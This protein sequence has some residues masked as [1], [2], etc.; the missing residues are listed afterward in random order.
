MKYLIFNES[1]SFIHQQKLLFHFDIVLHSYEHIWEYSRTFSN[2]LLQFLSIDMYLRILSKKIDFFF[3]MA[4]KKKDYSSDLQT[5]VIKHYSNGDSQREI[6]KKVLLSRSTVQSIIKKHKNS[7]CIGNLFGRCR[8]RKTIAMT[9]RLLKRKLKLDQWKS[10]RTVTFEFGKD[11][12]ILVSKSTVKR[13]AHE[14]ALFGRVVRKKPY[15]N[16]TNRLKRLKYAKERLRKPLR[17]LDTIVWSDESKFNLSESDGRIMV[18][19]S[20]YEEFDPKCTVP[21]VKHGGGSV[22]VWDCFTMV[23]K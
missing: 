15:V 17:F 8:K 11:L 14:V 5:F 1:K 23:E 9:D 6:S 19:R 16:K 18:W 12:G 10:A 2:V 20:R 4:P 3:A 7:K 22:M 21:I 13:Q